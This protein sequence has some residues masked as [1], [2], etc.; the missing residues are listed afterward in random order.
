MKKLL[1]GMAL[2]AVT[3][4]TFAA[5]AKLTGFQVTKGSNGVEIQVNG[6]D[7]GKP[8]VITAWKGKSYMLEFGAKL[9][10]KAT[11]E[12]VD[13]FGVESVRA[14]WF[15]ARPAKVRVQV[16]LDPTSQINLEPSGSGWKIKVTPANTVEVHAPTTIGA[17]KVS[18]AT[19]ATQNAFEAA[20]AFLSAGLNVAAKTPTTT[21]P[22][23][24]AT[25]LKES[26][27]AVF[28]KSNAAI[29]ALPALDGDVNAVQGQVKR[30]PATR[31]QTGK[32]AVVEA[33]EPQIHGAVA[34]G[35]SID[36]EFIN[37][38]VVQV[39]RA[40]AM[41]ADVNIVTAPDVKGQV[42]VA[43][44]DV[45]V[46][47]ALNLVTALTGLSYAKIN[48]TFVVAAD[49]S[50]LRKFGQ[51]DSTATTQVVPIYSGEGNMIK[52]A[53]LK[54]L[55]INGNG[56]FE[57]V[58]PSEEISVSSNESVDT[59]APQDDK[60][61]GTE[62][63]NIK[64][65]TAKVAA[66]KDTYV[67]LIGPAA[68]L[69]EVSRAVRL[70]DAQLCE[71]HGIEM[72]SNNAMVR[73]SYVPRGAKASSLLMAISGSTTP[74]PTYAKVGTVEIYATPADSL[75]DQVI[76][77]Y[78]RENEV[79]RLLE[80]LSSL[81][82]VDAGDNFM[83]YDVKYLDPRGVKQDL[84][85]QF[86]GIQVS[87]VP[88]SA[89]APGLFKEESQSTAGQSSSSNQG[90][91]QQQTSLAGDNGSL[92][93]GITLPFASAEK[94]SYAMRVVIRG[95]KSAMDRAMQYLA[96]VD[97]EPKQLALELR[98]MDLS[99]EDGLKLGIDW[100]ALTSAGVNMLRVNQGI[101]SGSVPGTV[102]SNA[103]AGGR[104]LNVAA[105]LD[106]IANGRNLIARPNLFA[107]DGRQSELFVGD[108]IRYVESIQST[109][110]GVTVTSKEL[111][112]GVRLAVLPRIGGNGQVTLDLR[113]VV[114]TLNGFTNVPGGGSLPQ[115]SLRIAQNTLTMQDG[116]T[117]AIG[118]LIQDNDIKRVSGI[119][120]LKDLPI[121][122]KL[123]FS[124]TDNSR[125]RTE[126]VFFVTVHI[127]KK[128]T[129]GNAANPSG[130]E[131][132]QPSGG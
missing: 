131:P 55:P 30:E 104:S 29:A 2:A 11:K 3:S 18:V 79:V 51:V 90:S 59:G 19:N 71:A 42:T 67:M 98:V 102:S 119:P 34:H 40:I 50:L 36:F 35:Q 74:N 72:P 105:T 62:G 64:T 113:P 65:T 123:L 9:V 39:L 107:Y 125:Q 69:V 97:I 63:T 106:Q 132:G 45:S 10:G 53:V 94:Q 43:L 23:A 126:M 12:T 28:T 5:D 124:R 84:E 14:G 7:L 95:G 86:P 128:D 27:A 81:D 87:L 77:L 76:S 49:P 13:A 26:P 88:A 122:G 85:S 68:R 37:T 108:V 41:Q 96:K 114:S 99:K 109:Q 92:N 110:T 25:P 129:R 118:G 33:P 16:T 115:T 78:G 121:L 24:T 20:Q 8:K 47:E 101:N 130:H 52:T 116:E 91:G 120:I 111:P 38:D 83:V 80:N 46:T 58:L 57:I 100:G 73:K 4:V 93:G 56:N 112:I 1:F 21:Q 70:I 66:K 89:A 60:N 44:H 75:G 22:K 48:N 54:S 61:K 32:R 15:S 82:Q 17:K 117:I 127:V 31:V 6:E 103:S